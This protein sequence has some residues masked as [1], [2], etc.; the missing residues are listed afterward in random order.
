RE[1]AS[2]LRSAETLRDRLENRRGA[3]GSIDFDLPAPAVLLHRQGVMTGIK[4]EPRNRAHRMIEEF[5]LAANEAVA[6]WLSADEVPCLFRV[7]DAPDP[8][9]IE[10]LEAFAKSLGLTL[11]VGRA[12]VR[13]GDIQRLLE[14]AE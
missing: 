7:H 2:M 9:K 13:P 1:V 14:D 12:G 4:I 6:T 8:L 5:M 11:K 10:G 3:R